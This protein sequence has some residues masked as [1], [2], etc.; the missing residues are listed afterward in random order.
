MNDRQVQHRIAA[1]RGNEF[2][3]VEDGAYVGGIVA[4]P[5]AVLDENLELM[6]LLVAHGAR[7]DI[8]DKLWNATPLD[9]A[10]HQG[11]DRARAWL[12]RLGP[13]S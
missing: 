7:T 6:D 9:W 11:K 5:G 1:E 12:G 10:I 8:A 3:I 4:D 13:R 2:V